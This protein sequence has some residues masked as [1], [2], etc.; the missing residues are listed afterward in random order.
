MV[1]GPKSGPIARGRWVTSVRSRSLFGA[2]ATHR[3]TATKTVTITQPLTI[4]TL[5][6]NGGYDGHYA[7]WET[8]AMDMTGAVTIGDEASAAV[9]LNGDAVLEYE[10]TQPDGSTSTKTG[11]IVDPGTVDLDSS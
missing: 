1:S 4:A 8:V 3:L 11:D 5:G 2:I 10:Y 6:G 7:D 9:V